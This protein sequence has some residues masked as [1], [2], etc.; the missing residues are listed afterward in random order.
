MTAQGRLVGS[1][2]RRIGTHQGREVHEVTL[3]AEGGLQAQILT[4]AR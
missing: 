4:L 3:S 1:G 2:P